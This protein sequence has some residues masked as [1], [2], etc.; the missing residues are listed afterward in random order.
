MPRVRDL[1]YRFR[2]SAAPGSATAAGVPA[3]RARDLAAELAPVFAALADTERECAAIVEAARTEAARVR[4]DGAA[5]VEALRASGRSRVAA[6]RAAAAAETR[7]AGAGDVAAASQALDRSVAEL[8]ERAERLLPSYA[9][10]VV[11]SVR[12]LVGEPVT[13]ERT[14]DPGG[15]PS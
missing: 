15:G 13:F 3:D 1:L 5:R 6:E 2:P 9:D 11:D 4:T 10:A 14:G 12:A 7:Q 8:L